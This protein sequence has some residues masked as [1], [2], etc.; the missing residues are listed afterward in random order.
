[1]DPM[2]TIAP[3][4]NGV[5]VLWQ[6]DLDPADGVTLTTPPIP[7]LNLD[8][9]PDHVA[10]ALE[11]GYRHSRSFVPAHEIEGLDS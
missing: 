3:D 4:A 8:Q 11:R 2:M 5:S 9:L 1:M 10:T 6:V 7:I